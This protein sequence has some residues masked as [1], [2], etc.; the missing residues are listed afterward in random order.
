MIVLFPH[1]E[2]KNETEVVRRVKTLIFRPYK[3]AKDT[4]YELYSLYQKNL[5]SP[6]PPIFPPKFCLSGSCSL[7]SWP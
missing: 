6:E 4:K 3:M 2:S 7:H 5:T 1:R